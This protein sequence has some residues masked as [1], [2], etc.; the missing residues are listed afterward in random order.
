MKYIFSLL[1]FL[2]PYSLIHAQVMINEIAWMGTVEN[3]NAEWIELYNS[4]AEDIDISNWKLIAR[5]GAPSITLKGIIKSYDYFLLERTSDTSLLDVTADQIYAGVLGNTGEYLE[6]IDT[7]GK[8]IDKIDSTGKWIAGNN[9][10]KDT[11]QRTESGK[12]ITA[13]PTPKEKNTE[14][15]V[16]VDDEEDEDTIQEVKSEKT[17]EKEIIFDPFYTA[18]VSMKE[19]VIERVPVKF[20]G[21]I[22]K[23]ISKTKKDDISRGK[24]EWS[25]G[26][27]QSYFFEKNTPVTYTYQKPGEYVVI[28]K[29]YE[30]IFD[31]E[32]KSVYQKVVTVIPATVEISVDSN[33]NLISLSNISTNDI[34][35]L[36]WTIVQNNTPFQFSFKSSTLLRKNS[37]IHIP[38]QVHGLAY[39]TSNTI[40]LITPDGYRVP[41]KETNKQ[42]A[43]TATKVAQKQQLVTTLTVDTPDQELYQAAQTASVAPFAEKDNLFY[44]LLSI[45]GIVIV[46]LTVGFHALTHQIH[47]NSS[48]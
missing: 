32:P 2:F 29:Y 35:L 3:A 6:L 39:I 11:M 31:E 16:V 33:S 22:T 47:K 5:D 46:G 41:I 19:I 45:F 9:T 37:I 44:I 26:D 7:A 36:G 40:Q 27:G 38:S 20:S 42:T 24:F 15:A 28:F 8:V 17:T 13:T 21:T 18:Q 14:I 4:E 48:E 10:T 34:D 23:N 43:N 1:L 25:M 30:S 12:W